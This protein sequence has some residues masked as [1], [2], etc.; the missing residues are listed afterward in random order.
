MTPHPEGTGW[1]EV[2]CG[3]MFSGKTK[4]LIRR[5]R[6]AELARRRVVSFKPARD[7]RYDAQ[8]IV[9]H[10]SQRHD[11]RA[12]ETAEDLRAAVSEEAEVVGIDEVQFFDA[13]IVKVVDDLATAGKRVI[14]AGLDQD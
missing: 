1:I 10:G 12:V 7:N 3:P 14:I 5:L 6:R 13:G 2:I 11:G 8:Q 9:S 4:E